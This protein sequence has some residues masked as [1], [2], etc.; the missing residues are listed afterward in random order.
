MGESCLYLLDRH[1]DL[2]TSKA[3]HARILGRLAIVA[4]ATHK[5]RDA[6]S[7][8]SQSLRLRL[9]QHR[10]YVALAISAGLLSPDRA[11][12]MANRMGRGI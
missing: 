1:P 3:G 8:A 2:Q 6:L 11:V 5:R 10:S 4:A 9:R 7:Y 12:R